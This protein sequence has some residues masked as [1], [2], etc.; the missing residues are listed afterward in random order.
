[1]APSDLITLDNVAERIVRW[2]PDDANHL[3]AIVDMG[4]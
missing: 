4:R 1:M 2:H 3:Y